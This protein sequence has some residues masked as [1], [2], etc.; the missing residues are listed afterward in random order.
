MSKQLDPLK[1]T[2]P[3]LHR[4]WVKLSTEKQWYSVIQ[5]CRSWFGS[6]WQGQGKVRRKLDPSRSTHT[7]RSGVVVW[8]DVPDPRW[9]TWIAT[10][11]ALQV[12]ADHPEKVAK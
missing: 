3:E 7:T 8:F 9:A 1:T 2:A 10:K 5:E 12:Q 6:N 4:F 11:F